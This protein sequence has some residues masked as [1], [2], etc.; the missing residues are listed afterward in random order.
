VKSWVGFGNLR[1]LTEITRSEEQECGYRSLVRGGIPR[2]AMLA[3][4]GEDAWIK[5]VTA[6]ILSF[7]PRGCFLGPALFICLGELLRTLTENDDECF[8][9]S[10][11]SKIGGGL[12]QYADHTNARD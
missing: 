10:R 4:R 11:R 2:S 7:G 12:S 8:H 5:F 6:G 3:F 9:S 1:G